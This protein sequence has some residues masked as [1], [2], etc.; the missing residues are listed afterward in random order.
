MHCL[1][2]IQNDRGGWQPQATLNCS[3]VSTAF[4]LPL[5]TG[6]AVAGAALASAFDL[7][8]AADDASA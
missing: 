7:G 5:P 2:R 4:G 6:R 8:G 1:A 3:P